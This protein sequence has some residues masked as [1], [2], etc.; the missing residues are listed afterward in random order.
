MLLQCETPLTMMQSMVFY[1]LKTVIW[2]LKAIV[3][4]PHCMF[5][6]M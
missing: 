1:I 3:F 6:V 2:E 5:S 4:M